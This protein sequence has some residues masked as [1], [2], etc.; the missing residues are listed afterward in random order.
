VTTHE[1][2]SWPEFFNEILA[3]RRTHE[4]RRDDRGY[5]VGDTLRLCEYLPTEDKFTGRTTD[6][7]VTSL[8][9][10]ERPCA[11]SDAGLSE[12]FCILSIRLKVG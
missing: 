11:V 10:A 2:K 12:G 3:G 1:L 8:T 5:D 9:S 7:V 6:V 4:L